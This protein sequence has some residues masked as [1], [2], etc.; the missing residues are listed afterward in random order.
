MWLLPFYLISITLYVYH[1][2][3]VWHKTGAAQV[4]ES[5]GGKSLERKKGGGEC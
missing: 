3:K 4:H 5:L 2:P 1:V